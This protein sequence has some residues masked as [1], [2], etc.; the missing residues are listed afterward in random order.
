[1]PFAEKGE[2]YI[3]INWL[4]VEGDWEYNEEMKKLLA[5]YFPF[6]KVSI[7]EVT[8]RYDVNT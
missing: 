2:N 4:F 1:M 6:R 8:N 3:D 5:E 7:K